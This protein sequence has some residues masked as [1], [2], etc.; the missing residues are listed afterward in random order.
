MLYWPGAYGTVLTKTDLTGNTPDRYIYFNGQ[1]AA[2]VHSNLATHYFL[3]DGLGSLRATVSPAGAVQDDVDYYPWGAKAL[4][5]F[6]SG[7]TNT[8]TGDESDTESSTFHTDFRQLSASLGRWLRPDPYDGS[9]D[10]TNP[11]SFNRYSYVGNS[12]ITDIDPSG[13]LRLPGSLGGGFLDSSNFGFGSGWDPFLFIDED[14]NLLSSPYDSEGRIPTGSIFTFL[15]FGFVAPSNGRNC[16]V[17]PAS[18]GQYAAASA[19]VAAMTAQFLSGLGNANPTFGPNT[20]TSAVM[21]QSA[22]V[23][24][25]L[26]EYYMTGATHDLYSFGGAGYVNAG[27]NLVAQFVG[28]FR[29]SISG[30]ILSLTNTTSF[31][32]LTYDKGPQWQ[33]S[34]F[35]PMGNTHQTYQIGVTCH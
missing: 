10:A 4:G 2:W 1:V 28:S 34:S 22:G 35:G 5:S 26:N 29:W 15:W 31:K 6:T 16:S 8:F 17:A 20:A 9:Y 23:Q 27:A 18:A 11:Q 14:G 12:P 13:L 33:R 19:Q 32:S 3:R 21:G 30:G 7:A 24:D 25:A